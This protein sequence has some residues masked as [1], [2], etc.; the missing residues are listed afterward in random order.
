[1]AVANGSVIFQSNANTIFAVRASDGIEIWRR[2]T[3]P[4]VSFHSIP[5]FPDAPD[6]D[7]W[8]SSPLV[9]DGVAFIGSGDGNV[10]AF[11]LASGKE[12]WRFRTGGRVRATPTS[13]GASIFVGSFDGTMYALVPG[14]GQLKWKYKTEGNPYFPVGSIQS[15]AAVR[16][17]RVIFGSR[18]YNLYALDAESGRLLWKNLHKESWVV[19][20]PAVA[21]GRVYVGSSDGRFMR[22]NDAATGA[23][24]W[25]K[26]MDGNVFSSAAILDNALYVGTFQGTIVRMKAENG[27]S[28]GIQLQDRI[29][30]SPWIEGGIL[31][32]AASDG[33]IYALSNGALPN[34][35][36]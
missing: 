18:D 25:T 17:G 4:S 19:A 23:E 36:Q 11:D 32:V 31:F 8:A 24:I 1:M 12:R 9:Q 5:A 29:Y 10:Y 13:D 35:S 22:C 20:S 26:P 14:T 6:Y 33:Q 2:T 21:D 7:L 30:A 27:Q 3:G 15:S 34:Q 16:D 28:A